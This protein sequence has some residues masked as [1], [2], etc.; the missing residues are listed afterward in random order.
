MYP[1][2]TLW[3][4]AAR[5]WTEIAAH[6]PLVIGE[7]LLAM[8][9]AGPRPTAAHQAEMARMVIEK[10]QAVAESTAAMWLAAMHGQQAAWQRAL[11]AGRFVPE[12]ADFALGAATARRYGASL[13]PIS[14]RVTAN[15]RRL[16]ARKR[17]RH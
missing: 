2:A 1:Y 14:R 11:R 4:T 17:P 7:R 16:A 13:K 6:A 15:A 12:P 10:G 9:V 3:L 8:A 5:Y